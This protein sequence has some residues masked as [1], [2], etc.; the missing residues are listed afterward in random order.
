MLLDLFPGPMLHDATTVALPFGRAIGSG[1]G[2]LIDHVGRLLSRLGYSGSPFTNLVR[3]D[4]KST[5]GIA[6]SCRLDCCVEC[7]Q[8][9]LLGNALNGGHDVS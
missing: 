6:C 5:T 4:G 3:H 2:P 9:G 7:Q 1:S 8:I